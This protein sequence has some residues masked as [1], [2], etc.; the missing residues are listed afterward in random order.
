[1]IRA[2]LGLDVIAAVVIWA[3]LRVAWGALHWRPW[4]RG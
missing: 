3:V 4:E 2:G 1:M